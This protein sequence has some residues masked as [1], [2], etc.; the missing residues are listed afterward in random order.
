MLAFLP[1]S[2]S[3]LI[4]NSALPFNTFRLR[5]PKWRRWGVI[6]A[7]RSDYYSTLNVSRNST[8]KEIKSS[9]RKLARETAG[10]VSEKLRLMQLTSIPEYHPD[11]NKS[12]G[13]EEK[14]KEISAAYEVLSDDEKRSL[15]DRFGEAGLEGEYDR[16]NGGS[17]GVDPFDFFDAFFDESNG[18]FGRRGEPGGMN[19][20]SRSK[21]NQGLDVRY[22][23]FLSFEESIFGKQEEIEVS[24]FEVCDNCGGTGAKSSSCIKTCTNCGG[25]GGVMKTQKTPFGIMSQ[26]IRNIGNSSVLPWMVSTCSKCGGDG[27]I[28]TSHCQ[29]CGGHG[30]VQSK[31]SIEVIIPP[32]VSDGATMQ[33]PSDVKALPDGSRVGV[34]WGMAGDLYLVLHVNE[35]HGIWRDGLNLYSKVNV[36]YTEAILGTVK[37]CLNALLLQ[38]D[39]ILCLLFCLSSCLHWVG[40]ETVEGLRD[41]Q[42]PSGTQP[43]DSVKLSYMGV[44]DINR[45]SRRGDHNFVVNVL[46]PKDIRM[47][48]HG[49]LSECLRLRDLPRCRSVLNGTGQEFEAALDCWGDQGGTGKKGFTLDI[50]IDLDSS[51]AKENFCDTERILVEKLASMRTTCNDQPVSSRVQLRTKN[52]MLHLKGVNMLHLCGNQS[53]TSCGIS[54]PMVKVL[55]CP[56]PI[57]QL[58]MLANLRV[59]FFVKI[60]PR[61]SSFKDV[62]LESNMKPKMICLPLGNEEHFGTEDG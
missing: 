13:A 20:N 25:K 58:D 54:R 37:S 18:P 4:S 11:L 3:P 48:S 10:L 32:G 55:Q 62:N 50:V 44:P 16:S 57:S 38:Q 34:A 30:K 28:I 31:Q 60:N 41:L 33:M 14:F 26:V 53:R 46:I 56:L 9:Y 23:L 5:P 27:K 40:V 24:C 51:V 6:R 39:F 12:P 29:S 45:P 19:F 2:K 1:I 49:G 59:K 42:I 22:D 35:K 15:Y 8:L 61:L 47:V 36:D 52:I 21:G 7:A 43:G 17:K